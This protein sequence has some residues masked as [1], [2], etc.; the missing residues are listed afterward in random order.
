MCNTDAHECC[1]YLFQIHDWN[2]D[3][4]LDEHCMTV[5]LSSYP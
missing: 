5:M 4:T 1:K 3:G 2:N